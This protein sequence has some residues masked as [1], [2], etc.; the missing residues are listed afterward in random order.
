MDTNFPDE[1]RTRDTLGLLQALLLNNRNVEAFLEELAELAAKTMTPPASCGI[2]IKRDDRYYT[3]ASSDPYAAKLDET[4]YAACE[5]PCLHALDTS[6]V[7]DMPDV[8]EAVD[9]RWPRYA[10][11]AR[12]LGLRSSLSIPLVVEGSILGAM[13]VY[14]F[15]EP[16]AFVQPA[17]SDLEVFATQA[18][19]ALAVALREAE[20]NATNSQLE[21]A[22]TSRSVI[23]QALGILMSQQHCD[24]DGAFALLRAH[25]QNINVKLRD[26]AIGIVRGISDGEPAPGPRFDRTP[27]RPTPNTA[28]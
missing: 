16:G 28:T 19:T 20:R 14:S 8:M 2:T 22:L 10:E 24:A 6:Q 23:D 17:R 15:Q 25:S 9:D 3:V 11:H 18:S 1:S 7:V 21:E 12:S 5:G 4:Q 13:N 27:A 26:V